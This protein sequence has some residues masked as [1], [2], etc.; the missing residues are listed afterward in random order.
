[1]A[2]L[3]AKLQPIIPIRIETKR[4]SLTIPARFT[5]QVYGLLKDYKE[6]EDWLANGDLK[7]IINIPA[8]MQLDFYDKLN[9]I[10][11]GAV[12]S[13]ELKKKE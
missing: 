9:A 7:A 8:G 6:S 10:T 13:E 3:V 1:M 2:E 4:I 5:G 12:L 11:H